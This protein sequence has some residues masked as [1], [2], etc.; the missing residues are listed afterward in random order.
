[1]PLLT[2]DRDLKICLVLSAKQNMIYH[3]KFNSNLIVKSCTFLCL[4][5]FFWKNY[6]QMVK[7]IK[8][9]INQSPVQVDY[10]AR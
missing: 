2:Y 10:L 1:M 4:V 3:L 8:V 6:L 9:K 5:Y 7:T